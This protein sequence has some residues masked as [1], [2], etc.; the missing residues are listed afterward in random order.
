MTK[1]ALLL[2]VAFAVLLF[3]DGLTSYVGSPL[4]VP[5]LLAVAF[6]ELFAESIYAGLHGEQRV[7][8]AEL[9]LFA[10]VAGKV[11]VWF[12]LLSLGY[13]L[14]GLLVGLLVGS[15][16]QILV[17]LR[18][19]SIRPAMPA[20]RHFESLFQFS[21]YSWLGALRERAWIW[22]DTLVLGFF[23]SAE[24]V[25]VY[26]LSWRLSAAFFLVAS[27]ISSTLFANVDLLQRRDGRA[28]VRDVVEE[29]LVYTGIVAIPG[30]VGGL[31]VAKSLL[32]AFGPAYVVGY[33][34]LILLILAR[35]FH[36]YE[37]VFAKVIN[38]LDRP[39][40]TFRA[41]ATFVTL[42]VVGNVLAIYAFGWVGAAVATLVS[43]G[44]RTLLSYRFL[45]SLIDVPIPRREILLEVLSAALMGGA[46]LYA[47]DGVQLTELETALVIGGGGVLYA[48]LLLVFVGRVRTRVRRLVV[49]FV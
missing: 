5:F 12:V 46:L 17:G 33:A 29:S 15:G 30:V 48:L 6:L 21:R 28:A 42:N 2:P 38:A 32:S 13:G 26:E 20:R 31:V 45:H 9:S 43:M 16:L 49:G 22:T 23:V 41:D 8:R 11:A 18:F 27:A 47:T 44:V 37:V 10:N 1:A 24:F 4:A 40:L 19:L 34:A 7:G 25:G 35:L 14:G 39:D 3:R 36:S